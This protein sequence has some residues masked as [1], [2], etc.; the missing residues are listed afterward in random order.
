LNFSVVFDA[1][2]SFVPARLPFIL[3]FAVAILGACVI[4]A[5]LVRQESQRRALNGGRTRIG[6]TSLVV[7]LFIIITGSV[8]VVM[9]TGLSSASAQDT[10]RAI[11]SS[12]VVEGSVEHFHPMPGGGHDSERFEVAGVHFEYSHWSISQGFNQDVTVG[13]P[14]REGLYVRIHYVRLADESF[15]TIVRLEIRQ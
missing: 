2:D 1:A 5:L 8:I 4:A 11:E 10:A 6:I 3:A 12:A 13:G 15:G 14:I 9:V 7:T